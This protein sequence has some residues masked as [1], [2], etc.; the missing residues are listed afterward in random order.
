MHRC[1]QCRSK[2]TRRSK[3]KGFVERGPLTLLCLRPFRCEDCQH[4]FFRWPM[5]R[6][7]FDATDPKPTR[8]GD[9]RDTEEM[10]ATGL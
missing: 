2:R 6:S 9:D 4:R 7:H 5:I 8:H 3:R 10:V 1:P